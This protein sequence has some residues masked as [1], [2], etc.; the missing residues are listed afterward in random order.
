METTLPEATT[1]ALVIKYWQIILALVAIIAGWMRMG[2]KI[3]A[4]NI[5]ISNLETDLGHLTGRTDSMSPV[6]LQIQKDIV[7]IKTSLMYIQKEMN[8]VHA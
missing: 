8:T 5:K 4:Q 2:G 7:E 6:F 3:E 1:V